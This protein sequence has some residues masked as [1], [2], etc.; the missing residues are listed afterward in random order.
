MIFNKDQDNSSFKMSNL[1]SPSFKSKEDFASIQ[2]D[3]DNYFFEN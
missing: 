3:E 2:K 1:Y